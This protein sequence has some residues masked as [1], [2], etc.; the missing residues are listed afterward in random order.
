MNTG[1]TVFMELTDGLDQV[2][3]NPRFMSMMPYL[4]RLLVEQLNRADIRPDEQCYAI[5]LIQQ[6]GQHEG[7]LVFQP[8]WGPKEPA[9]TMEMLGYEYSQP[10]DYGGL[11]SM[12]TDT[13]REYKRY[14]TYMS[15]LISR[16]RITRLTTF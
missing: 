15:R 4:D 14:G 1:A 7:A 13:D 3:K 5:A 11:S 12:S 16:A 9:G 6:R 2:T 8:A 10:K